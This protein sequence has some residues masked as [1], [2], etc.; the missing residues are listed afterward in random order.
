[1]VKYPRI[2]QA[3]FNSIEIC[4]HFKLDRRHSCLYGQPSKGW[5]CCVCSKIVWDCQG[6][7]NELDKNN[8]VTLPWVPGDIGVKGNE[9]AVKFVTSIPLVGLESFYGFGDANFKKVL[10]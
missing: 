6:E 9:C 7:L 1:M 5:A 2:S 8:E 4:I 3:E 10:R